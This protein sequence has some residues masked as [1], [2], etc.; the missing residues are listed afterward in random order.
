MVD[1]AQAFADRLARL[2]TAATKL[3]HICGCTIQLCLDSAGL[4]VVAKARGSDQHAATLMPWPDVLAHWSAVT[5]AMDTMTAEI[6]QGQG[7]R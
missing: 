4:M 6:G 1:D 2:A 3:G 7:A 5:A